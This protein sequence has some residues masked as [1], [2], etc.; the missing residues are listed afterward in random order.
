MKAIVDEQLRSE[1]HLCDAI[2]E[3]ITHHDYSIHDVRAAVGAFTGEIL[4][5]MGDD[6]HAAALASP[7]L[8]DA[9]GSEQLHSRW[10]Q[11]SSRYP[12]LTA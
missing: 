11:H 6:Q 7:R 4:G 5:R 2:A 9:A 3:L 1:I 12:G 8:S 10:A